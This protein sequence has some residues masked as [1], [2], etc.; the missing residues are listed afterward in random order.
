MNTI[1]ELGGTPFIAPKSNTTGAVG[2][3]FERMYHY[4]QFRRE[5]FLRH[6]H[7][8]SNVESVFSAVK[9]KF[10]DHVRSRNDVAMVNEVLCKFLL[11]NLCCV[12]LSQIELG[13]E[14]EFWPKNRGDP[15]RS[16]NGEG[17]MNNSPSSA[18]RKGW[19]GQMRILSGHI[20]F[21][22]IPEYLQGLLWTS[23]T[24]VNKSTANKCT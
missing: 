15:R 20:A 7:K 19:R 2:G 21:R 9:R 5:D 14:A 16:P 12:I 17:N 10:G 4:Y 11:N 6:Y 22:M 18:A 3:L 1:T 24:N 8:R 23:E 13:I